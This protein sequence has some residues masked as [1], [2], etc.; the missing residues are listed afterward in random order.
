MPHVIV[1]LDSGKS[2]RQK[3]ALAQAVTEAVMSAL[4]YGRESVSVGIEDVE[5]KDWTEQVYK[6]NIMDKPDTIYKKP[7]YTRA[8]H[9]TR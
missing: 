1:K 4:H 8:E 9:M 5:P 6:P 2:E 7:G 3:Q